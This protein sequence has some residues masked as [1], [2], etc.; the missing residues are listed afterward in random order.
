MAFDDLITQ[1]KREIGKEGIEETVETQLPLP[2]IA[3]EY[4]EPED[5]EEDEPEDCSK[6]S[7]CGGH[8]IC[9]P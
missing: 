8:G 4:P 1:K 3:Q 2:G 6:C 9:P 5:E 7:G